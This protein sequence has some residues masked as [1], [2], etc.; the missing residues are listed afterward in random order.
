MLQSDVGCR[1]GFRQQHLIAVQSQTNSPATI[2]AAKAKAVIGKTV[3]MEAMKALTI[4]EDCSKGFHG[5]IES[6]LD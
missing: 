6:F 1:E 3:P 5:C 4:E 2:P